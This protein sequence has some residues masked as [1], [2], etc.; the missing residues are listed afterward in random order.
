[1]PISMAVLLQQH[2]KYLSVN[3]FPDAT[4]IYS[5]YSKTFIVGVFF[6]AGVHNNKSLLYGTIIDKP[7]LKFWDYTAQVYHMHFPIVYSPAV[8]TSIQIA[9]IHMC[10]LEFK[11]TCTCT[12]IET[13]C[14]YIH[15]LMWAVLFQ[16][17]VVPSKGGAE[18]PLCPQL[19]KFPPS[20]FKKQTNKS[21]T[22]HSLKIDDSIITCQIS[23]HLVP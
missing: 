6:W 23:S 12:Y 2:V 7:D 22:P 5:G 10:I 14:T 9:E 3:V 4:H 17:M 20:P 11:T 13:T 8:Y 1:M 19:L 16:L 15:V 18:S 21:T